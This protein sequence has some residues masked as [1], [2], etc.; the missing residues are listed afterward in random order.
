VGNP[1]MIAAQAAFWV[2]L[3]YDEAS[4][5]AAWD[6]AKN[7]NACDR[8]GLR[9]TVPR[10]GLA[11]RIAGRSLG[12][13]A[14]EAL[15]IARSGLAARARRDAQGRDETHFLQPLEAIVAAGRS[16]AEERLAEYEGRWQ[17]SVEP[18]FTEC[19]F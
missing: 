7:W 15:T 10:L 8:E 14:A 4:L 2:G 1:A 12:A 6:I 13:V 9:A 16:L 19:V 18:A 5:A 3:L 11:A 17:R